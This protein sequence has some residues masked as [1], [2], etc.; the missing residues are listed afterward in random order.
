MPAA[1]RTTSTNTNT[2]TNTNYDTGDHMNVVIGGGSGIG[3]ATAPLLDGTTLIADRSDGDVFC[4]LS[5]R[6]SL[7]VVAARVDKLDALVITAGVSPVQVDAHT[8]LDVDLAGMARVLD[9]FDHLVG[10][11]TAVVCIASMAAYLAID[12]VPAEA[13]AVLD[14]P[15]SEAIFGLSDN[16]GM[17][18]AFAKVGV[19]RLARR[20]ALE[21]GPRG[22]RCVS[23]SPGVIATPMGL[24]EMAAQGGAGDLMKLG[25]FGRPGRPEEIAQVIAFLCSPAASFITG[26]DILVDGGVVAATRS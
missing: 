23:L 22:G 24:A 4:D 3:A 19:Q 5:D 15:L 12:H 1:T 8:V 25:A 13:F 21:W 16:P 18:Y 6:A 9:A 11:G 17:A 7:D 14:E 20:K 10:D 2:N 26:T